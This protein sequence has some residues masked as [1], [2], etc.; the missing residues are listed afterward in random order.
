[1]SYCGTPGWSVVGHVTKV[2]D[3]HDVLHRRCGEDVEISNL[4]NGVIEADL[5]ALQTALSMRLGN[6][7]AL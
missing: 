4:I 6:N 5:S 1:M 3:I 2:G 7:P